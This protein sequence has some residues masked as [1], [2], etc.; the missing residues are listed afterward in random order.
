MKF[1]L[2][3]TGLGQNQPQMFPEAPKNLQLPYK[4]LQDTSI[5]I[6]TTKLR[7]Y[8]YIIFYSMDL[9]GTNQFFFRRVVSDDKEALIFVNVGTL[10]ALLAARVISMDG[11]FLSPP[12]GF[13]QLAVVHAVAFGITIPVAEFLMTGKTQAHYEA[14]LRRLLEVCHQLTGTLFIKMYSSKYPLIY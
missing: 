8:S 6:S 5:N 11:T 14:C 2:P 10:L 13:Y 12:R 7:I 4:R 9:N 1:E 3:C